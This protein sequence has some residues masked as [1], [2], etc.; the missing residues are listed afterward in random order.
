MTPL[1][2]ALVQRAC[3]Q[4]AATN[5]H[6]IRTLLE[7][8]RGEKIDLLVLPELHNGPYFCVSEEAAQFERAEPIPGP[9]TT[10]LGQLARELNAV[11][12]GS[13]FERRAAGLYHNSAVVLERD[14]SLAGCYRKMHIPDD[15]G[16]YEKYYFT[17]GDLPHNRPEQAFRPIQTSAG[18]LGVMVCWDQWYPEAARLMSLA[19]AELL[20][21]PTAIGWNPDDSADEQRRQRDAWI[22]VQRGHAIANG[23]PLVAVNRVGHEVD[24]SGATAG[25]RFWGSSFACGPQGELLWQAGDDETEIKLIGIDLGRSEQVRRAWPFLRDRRIDGY[26]DLVR[27]WRDPQ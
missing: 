6:A 22:T 14:G 7:P 2:V 25:S 17:P 23:L 4:D 3:Q 26:G 24:P 19:G 9:S 13:L 5:L 8:L 11:V 12:I 20:I 21:Y 16:Y 27:R 15:P 1:Q 10:A 18:M